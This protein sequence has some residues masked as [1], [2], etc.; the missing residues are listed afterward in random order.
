MDVDTGEVSQ[1]VESG[2]EMFEK[3]CPRYTLWVPDTTM[4]PYF[5]GGYLD[6]SCF[7]SYKVST[8]HVVYYIQGVPKVSPPP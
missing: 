8:L 4:L 3:L 6:E 2:P 5:G 1:D 7:G